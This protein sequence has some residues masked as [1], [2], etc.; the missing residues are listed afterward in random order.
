MIEQLLNMDAS[1]LLGMLK[2][3]IEKQIGREVEKGSFYLNPEKTGLL[4]VIEQQEYK[5]EGV[6]RFIV[7]FL[8]KK[9][10]KEFK[11]ANIQYKKIALIN[12]DIDFIQNVIE[13]KVYYIDNSNEKRFFNFNLIK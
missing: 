12:A 13:T 3:G 11:K 2:Q 9:I 7:S 6:S 8:E 1:G 10:E 5:I 4:L